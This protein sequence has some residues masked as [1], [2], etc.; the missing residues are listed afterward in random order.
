LGRE[1][2]EREKAR[3]ENFH[4][5]LTPPP[6]P[7]HSFRLR[8]QTN[9]LAWLFPAAVFHPWRGLVKSNFNA[10]YPETFLGF[11]VPA[12]AG[13]RVEYL[14]PCCSSTRASTPASAPPRG[15]GGSAIT[16]SLYRRRRGE[17]DVKRHPLLDSCMEM[18]D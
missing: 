6:P 2:R 7:P 5:S 1:W 12:L 8:P 9:F 4:F 15:V 14:L 3:E 17:N 11:S 16:R 10:G 13:L 18:L